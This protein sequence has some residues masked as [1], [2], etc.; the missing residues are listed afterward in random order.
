MSLKE[1][2]GELVT[3]LAQEVKSLL[4]RVVDRLGISE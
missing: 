4:S 3:K 1:K 2:L